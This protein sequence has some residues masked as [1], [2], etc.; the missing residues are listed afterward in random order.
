MAMPRTLTGIPTIA[1]SML[2]GTIPTIAMI[3]WA[4][5]PRAFFMVGAGIL[6]SLLAF[7]RFLAG[8]L[9]FLNIA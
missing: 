4:V 5:A 9:Q 6:A 7:F 3:I 1:R 2:T 8:Q